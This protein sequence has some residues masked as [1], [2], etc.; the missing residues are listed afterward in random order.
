MLKEL[1]VKSCMYNDYKNNI[2]MDVE[3]DLGE[4]TFDVNSTK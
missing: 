1:A 3:F 4:R 2:E